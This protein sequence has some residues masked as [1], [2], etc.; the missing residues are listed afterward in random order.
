MTP[1]EVYFATDMSLESFAGWLRE[2]LNLPEI[3]RSP[4]QVEQRRYGVNYGGDY[5]LF[6]A[7]GFEFLLFRNQ[8]EVEIPEYADYHLYLIVKSAD[9]ALNRS[10]AENIAR[11]VEAEGVATRV[12]SVA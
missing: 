11:L 7:L 4:Y 12:D 6:E 8:G 2:V 5:Y 10:M 9:D 1:Y 3:N